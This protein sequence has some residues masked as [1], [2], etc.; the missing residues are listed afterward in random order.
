MHVSKEG[1]CEAGGYRQL[2]ISVPPTGSVGDL[3]SRHSREEHR[4]PQ[5]V[6]RHREYFGWVEG[7]F[8][9]TA[10]EGIAIVE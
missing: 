10:L 6:V 9:R 4:W 3:T 5:A 1:E 2:P 7:E 8:G